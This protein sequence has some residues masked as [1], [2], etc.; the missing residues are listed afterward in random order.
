MLSPTA[1]I[2]STHNTVGAQ[3][4]LTL[5]CTNYNN[6]FVHKACS[7]ES[8][9]LDSIL[10]L[11]DNEAKTVLVGGTDELTD[12]SFAILKRFNLYKSE[13]ADSLQL[14]QSAT[15]GTIAGEGA[16]FFL[17]STEA[18]DKDYAVIDGITT[19]YKPANA[20][21]IESSIIKF[22]DAHNVSLS[23]IDCVVSG[24]DG[25]SRGA[26]THNALENGIFAGKEIVYYKQL[27]GDYPTAG[28]FAL[29]LAANVIY[30][31]EPV[32]EGILYS[33]PGKVLVYN[34]YQNTHHSFMLL[35]AS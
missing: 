30:R 24:K 10:L 22:L 11:K 6:T 28:S 26:A 25:D 13:S 16:N 18:S 21:V 8:A 27:T 2:Q 14:M 12:H 7:F 31:N 29:W 23:D 19:L 1:F 35:S 17:L 5:Q 4:A 34:N 15:E 33:K 3:I 20:N 32:F 9:L